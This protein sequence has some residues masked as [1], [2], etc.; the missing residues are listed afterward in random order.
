MRGGCNFEGRST[1]SIRADRQRRLERREVLSS[2]SLISGPLSSVS[3]WP[4]ARHVNKNRCH[5]FEHLPFIKY[6]NPR[7]LSFDRSS[8]CLCFLS[9]LRSLHSAESKLCK[10]ETLTA[11]PFDFQRRTV[12]LFFPLCFERSIVY[13]TIVQREKERFMHFYL[14]R[15]RY[16][17]LKR[18]RVSLMYSA[19]RWN[20][21]WSRKFNVFNRARPIGTLWNFPLTKQGKKIL[22]LSYS[23]NEKR[24]KNGAETKRVEL[25]PG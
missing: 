16:S 4:G 2:S 12:N 7:L 24:K 21:V 11:E 13:T 23:N 6:E 25:N 8:R 22:C 5:L 20:I 9:R 17:R 10:P 3:T 15:D 14:I 1:A 18:R 19:S